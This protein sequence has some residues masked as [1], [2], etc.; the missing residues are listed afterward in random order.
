[1]CILA[2]GRKY[3]CFEENHDFVLSPSH[4]EHLDH[5]YSSRYAYI[6]DMTGIWIEQSKSCD[7]EVMN[8]R[9]LVAP[10]SVGMQNNSAYKDVISNM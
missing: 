2:Y 3:S 4:E 10:Y 6:C 1:M 9:F 8:E 7:V 5:M